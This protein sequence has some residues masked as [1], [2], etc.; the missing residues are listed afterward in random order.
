MQQDS[1]DKNTKW[2]VS[3]NSTTTMWTACSIVCITI[4]SDCGEYIMIWDKNP[5]PPKTI[6]QR[7]ALFVIHI[8][9]LSLTMIEIPLTELF[10]KR[11]CTWSM[12]Y[13]ARTCPLIWS[14]WSPNLRPARAAGDPFITRHTNTPLLM[15]ATRT[16]TFPFPSLHRINWNR[17]KSGL[18]ICLSVVVRLWNKLSS[19]AKRYLNIRKS[20]L[21]EF[22]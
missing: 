2:G 10:L 16:P 5:V 20:F 12:V 1:K 8:T 14:S 3:Y 4:P 11:S 18:T 13:P 7:K 9:H 6:K 22:K 15:D 21:P 19:A 17:S